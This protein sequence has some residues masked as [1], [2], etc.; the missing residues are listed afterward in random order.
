MQIYDL[1]SNGIM[2][3]ELA[4]VMLPEVCEAALELFKIVEQ[5]N[6]RLEN[7]QRAQPKDYDPQQKIT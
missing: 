3:P 2:R 6:V 1:A 7:Y 5:Q 4:A